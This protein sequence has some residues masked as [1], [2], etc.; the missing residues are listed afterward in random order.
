MKLFGI[1]DRNI[2]RTTLAGA[3]N[4]RFGNRMIWGRATESAL[5][6]AGFIELTPTENPMTEEV[7]YYYYYTWAAIDGEIQCIWHRE[8]IEVPAEG[9]LN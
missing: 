1:I 4:V 5:L 8:A 2:V 9:E 7:G 3:R 6:A